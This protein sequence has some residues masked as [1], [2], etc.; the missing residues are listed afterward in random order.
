MS[1]LFGYLP[2]ISNPTAWENI[3]NL[4]C[5]NSPTFAKWVSSLIVSSA[6]RS[7]LCDNIKSISQLMSQWTGQC[8]DLILGTRFV[9]MVISISTS[10]HSWASASVVDILP[11]CKKLIWGSTGGPALRATGVI[12]VCWPLVIFSK[13]NLPVDLN[14]NSHKLYL[15]LLLTFVH[16]WFVHVSHRFLHT[17]IRSSSKYWVCRWPVSRVNRKNVGALWIVSA[18]Y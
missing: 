11:T 9:V 8:L 13:N 2:S 4:I 7:L 17:F 12:R 14:I 16:A 10:A 1:G 5:C 15:H 3:F 18:H 6:D